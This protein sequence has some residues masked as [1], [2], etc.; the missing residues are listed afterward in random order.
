MA[1]Y[2]ALRETLISHLCRKAQ[3]GEEFE[4]EFPE[5]TKLSDN[6]ELVIPAEEPD[7]L[8]TGQGG[9]LKRR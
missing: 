5:G 2:R 8:D 6:I 1:K 7:S 4:A 9:K 3:E